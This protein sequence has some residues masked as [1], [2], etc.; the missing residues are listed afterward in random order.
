[1]LLHGARGRIAGLPPWRRCYRNWPN[2]ALQALGQL[3][4]S[5]TV[6]AS[7]LRAA[8]RGTLNKFD[9]QKLR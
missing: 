7:Q 8:E 1:V 5:L 4:S 2:K 9:V 3:Q 6:A